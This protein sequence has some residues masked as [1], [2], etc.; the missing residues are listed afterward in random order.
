M[1]HG[2]DHTTIWGTLSGTALGI[3]ATISS[4]D[5]VKTII[6]GAIGATVSFGVSL[7]WNKVANYFK[8][9]KD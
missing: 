6:L 5:I 8:Q 2:N 7:L 4:F 1:N 9:Q 3:A